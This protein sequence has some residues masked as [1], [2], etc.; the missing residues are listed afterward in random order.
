MP[1]TPAG[2]NRAVSFQPAPAPSFRQNPRAFL[3]A[4]GFDVSVSWAQI[5]QG[6]MSGNPEDIKGSW[7][8]SHWVSPSTASRSA[9]GAASASRPSVKRICDDLNRAPLLGGGGVD[10]FM[11]VMVA[12]P[13]SGITPPTSRQRI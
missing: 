9:C 11:N 7:G 4:K 12:A 6:V 5:Y 10:T 1:V 3:Q 2:G 8:G 13:V